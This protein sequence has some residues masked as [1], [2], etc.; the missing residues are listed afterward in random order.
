MVS[1]PIDMKEA[2]ELASSIP[3]KG[4]R[5]M[6]MGSIHLVGDFLILKLYTQGM[7]I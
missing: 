2:I 3:D 4:T 7:G 5:I 1:V 6:V